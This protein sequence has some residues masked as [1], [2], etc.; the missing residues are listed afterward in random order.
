M[1]YRIIKYLASG[2]SWGCTFFVLIILLGELIAGDAFLEP[3]L[4]NFTK[5]ALGSI[6]V[7]IA[8]GSSSIIYTFD[9]IALW[10]RIVIHFFIG[11]TG[12]F[13][14]SYY[15]GWMPLGSVYHIIGYVIIEI[16][17]FTILWFCFYFLDRLE[18]RKVNRRLREMEKDETAGQ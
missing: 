11:L 15:A 2:I 10:L 12:F 14:I 1:L 6:L 17:I 9:K 5:Q 3:V 4:A 16:F 8:C 18:A 13:T 7:G